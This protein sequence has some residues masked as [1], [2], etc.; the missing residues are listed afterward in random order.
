MLPSIGSEALGQGIPLPL[1][2]LFIPGSLH[3]EP[4]FLPLAQFDQCLGPH[5]YHP[6][7][8]IL[9]RGLGGVYGQG[10]LGVPTLQA[11]VPHQNN[12]GFPKVGFFCDTP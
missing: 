6:A 11:Q 1:E 9:G 2:A 8:L 12:Q 3:K 7:P 10:S 5:Q 4:G